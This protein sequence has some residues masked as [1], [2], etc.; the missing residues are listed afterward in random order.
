MICYVLSGTL[1]PIDIVTFVSVWAVY[2]VVKLSDIVQL[3]LMS[4]LTLKF[5]S[6]KVERYDN[7]VYTFYQ[8]LTENFVTLA[9]QTCEFDFF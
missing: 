8:H 2:H 9:F 6:P 3:L 5:V 4:A 1:N 7:Y